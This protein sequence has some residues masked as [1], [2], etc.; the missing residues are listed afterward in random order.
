MTIN[1]INNSEPLTYEKINDLIQ[2]FNDL[3]K[4]VNAF[5]GNN[6]LKNLPQIDVYL[7]GTDINSDKKVDIIADS[8]DLGGSVRDNSKTIFTGTQSY[9]STAVFA[10]PPV[11]VCTV[12]VNDSDKIDSSIVISNVK[13][14]EFSYKIK[15]VENPT[16]LTSLKLNYIAIGI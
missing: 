15:L 6:R 1:K 9:L 4:N 7:G 2:Q 13:N 14:R 10:N 16:T 11:I 8:I 12:V 3:E 5:T